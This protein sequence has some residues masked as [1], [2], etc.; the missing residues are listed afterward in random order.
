MFVALTSRTPKNRLRAIWNLTPRR[1][2][3]INVGVKKRN[4][5]IAAEILQSKLK[6]TVVTGELCSTRPVVRTNDSATK[7]RISEVT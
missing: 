7:N 1:G 2:S 6:N 5:K 4:L 3:T